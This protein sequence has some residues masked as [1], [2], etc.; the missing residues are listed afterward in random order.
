MKISG[1][2]EL[3][4]LWQVALTAVLNDDD[5]AVIPTAISVVRAI[6]MKE[7]SEPLN[8]ALLKIAENQKYPA[9]VRVEALAAVTNGIT[10]PTAEQFK[11]LMDNLGEEASVST[12][13]AAVDA[14][15][16]SKLDTNYLTQLSEAVA[17]AGPLELNRLLSAFEQSTD[18]DVG[19]KLIAGLKRSPVLTSLRVD[20]VK[21][22]LQKFP[23]S[24]QSQAEELYQAI[25]IEAGR[26]QE[27]LNDLMASISDG[28]VRRGQVVFN[29]QKA[30]CTSCHQM[31]YKGGTIGP[32]LSRVGKIRSER[33]MLEAVVFP[34][35]SFVRS[36][37][38]VLIV[39]K[40]GKQVNGLIRRETPEEITLATGAKEEA[41]V[42]RADIEEIRPGTVSVMPAGLDTQLTRQ[43]IAD[44]IAFL[45]A[46]Q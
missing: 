30:A 29:S 22:R 24:V 36:Y 31:G 5:S 23:S 27:K 20:A 38:P 37:E 39:T 41:R 32:D 26:Q 6:P 13:S 16:K 12:R 18:Q 40:N 8:Q 7:S 43:Q 15:I 45:K 28:D 34:S 17:T 19:T 11:L 44:L 14:L 2:K 42:L 25:N 3:P 46:K 33:D 21:Q 1:Q 10:N 9:S 4:K 35:I